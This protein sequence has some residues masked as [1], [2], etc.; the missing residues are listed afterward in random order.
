M[1]FPMAQ[2]R[3]VYTLGAERLIQRRAARGISPGDRLRKAAGSS[4]IM[5]SVSMALTSM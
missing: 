1:G 4:V 2:N 3:S 5:G